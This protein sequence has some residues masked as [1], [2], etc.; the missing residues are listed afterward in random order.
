[1][2]IKNGTG[3][4]IR[5]ITNGGSD[6]FFYMARID[7]DGVFRLYRHPKGVYL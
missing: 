6:E 3:T 2:Y 5:D 1:M 7:P 4:V